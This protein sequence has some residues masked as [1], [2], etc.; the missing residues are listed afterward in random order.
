MP[1]RSL[2]AGSN[3]GEVQALTACLLMCTLLLGATTAIVARGSPNQEG[4]PAAAA[5]AS[6]HTAAVPHSL[7]VSLQTLGF[8]GGLQ[9][10]PGRSRRRPPRQLLPPYLLSQQARN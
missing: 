3:R 10:G 2:V 8:R 4:R 9:V 1:H 5:T 7:Q 6:Q